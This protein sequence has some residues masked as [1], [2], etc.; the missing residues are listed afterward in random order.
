MTVVFIF[1]VQQKLGDMVVCEIIHDVDVAHGGHEPC[2]G[3]SRAADFGEVFA[4][5]L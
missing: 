1:P 3:V 2:D 5:D 4:D